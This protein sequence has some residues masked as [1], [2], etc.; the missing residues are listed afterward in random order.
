MRN[1]LMR[2]S[3]SIVAAL[4]IAAFV[5]R[6][7]TVVF[8]TLLATLL[9]LVYF[10]RAPSRPPSCAPNNTILAPTDGKVLRVVYKN[11]GY[12]CVVVYLGLTDVHLQWYPVTGTVVSRRYI[13]GRFYPAKWLSKSEYN[14]RVSTVLRNQY[15]MVR[16]D[17]IAGQLARRVVNRATVGVRVRRGQEMGMIK[18]SSR[19]DIHLPIDS[20]SLAIREG[21]R[22]VG[23]VTPIATWIS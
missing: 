2:E 17:Q 10:Y 21:Q 5:L 20:V 1:Y 7:N 15:G 6:N 11:N 9:F 3:P 23:G 13:P 22:I 8:C 4:F 18:L 16:V 19:V 14:E 12:V